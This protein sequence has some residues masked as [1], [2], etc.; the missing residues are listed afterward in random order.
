MVAD[1]ID[2]GQ[3][4][5]VGIVL[6]DITAGAGF[7]DLLNEIVGLMHGENENLGGGG[8]GADAT[9]GFHTVEE[10]HADI[11]DGDIGFEFDG[12]FNGIATIHRFAADLPP[13][14]RF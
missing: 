4:N 11:E 7:D 14:A 1:G 3:E 10:R 6:E 13:R 5:A 8:S 12:F 9:R 2:G